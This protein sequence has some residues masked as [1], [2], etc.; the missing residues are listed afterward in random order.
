MHNA[1]TP[2]ICNAA[3]ATSERRAEGAKL[4][5][6]TP[7]PGLSTRGGGVRQRNRRIT[8]GPPGHS[9]CAARAWGADCYG[10]DTNKGG[11]ARLLR[12]CAV[13]LRC[14][15]RSGG[16][17]G[18][19]FPA[20]QVP[21]AAAVAGMLHCVLIMPAFVWYL[22]AACCPDQPPWRRPHPAGSKEAGRQR[23]TS[24]SINQAMP[25]P[26]PN[27]NQRRPGV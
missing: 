14:Q 5:G 22:S 12:R 2:Y 6:Q 7:G 26:K 8:G 27:D 4:G 25:L 21:H 15:W 16:G 10:T 17:Q 3:T 19:G 18:G 11:L 23:P 13:V 20:R 9:W 24:S 1:Y